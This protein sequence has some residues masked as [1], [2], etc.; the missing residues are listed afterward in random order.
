MW[1]ASDLVECLIFIGLALMLVYTVFVTVRFFR[2][3]FLARRTAFILFADFTASSEQSKKNSV[4]DLSRGVRTL[5][6]I[7]FAAPFLGLAGTCYGM[8]CLFA[9]AYVW[10]VSSIPLEISVAFVATAAGLIV[11]IPA[12]ISYNIVRTRLEKFENSGSSTLLEAIPRSYRFAQTL[13]LR[14]RF[15]GLPAFGLIG[16]PV[17]GLLIPVF[18]LMLAPAIPVGLPVHILNLSPHDYDPPPIIVSV[19]ATNGRVGSI[20]YVNSEE[21]SW[22]EL[23]NT[24][25]SQLKVRPHWVVYVEGKDYASWRD[26]MNVIDVARGLHAEVVLLTAAPNVGSDNGRNERLKGKLRRK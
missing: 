12:A 17:L 1:R 2:R 14:S 9:R 5:Q 22:D 19:I 6:S 15:S 4:A 25:R 10:G 24:L 11:A 13:P 8:L 20:L 21:T 26:V 16:A 23:R 7:A 18:A 3:Y